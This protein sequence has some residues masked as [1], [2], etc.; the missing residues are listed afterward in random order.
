MCEVA[1]RISR[2][3]RDFYKSKI[4]IFGELYDPKPAHDVSSI[5]FLASHIAGVLYRGNVISD[6]NPFP[7]DSYGSNY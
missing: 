7:Q 4:E 1:S 6:Q 5:L 3:L 2:N